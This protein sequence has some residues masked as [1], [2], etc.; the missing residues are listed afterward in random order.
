MSCVY[1]EQRT[2]LTIIMT[3]L[4][5]LGWLDVIQWITKNIRCDV[6]TEWD[7]W[8]IVFWTRSLNNY[9]FTCPYINFA[10][11]AIVLLS[12]KS[13]NAKWYCSKSATSNASNNH[14]PN[15]YF[16]K[17]YHTWSAW[18]TACVT[19]TKSKCH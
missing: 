1:K 3:F 6:Q 16:E 10:I 9:L 12:P 19:C 5:K 17:A 8:H 13:W 11:S 15:W 4:M 2:L 7:E 18:Y 14:S